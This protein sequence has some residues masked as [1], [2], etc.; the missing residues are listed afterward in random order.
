M[1]RFIT[2]KNVP[3]NT[4]TSSVSRKSSDT[5]GTKCND[6][7]VLAADTPDSTTKPKSKDSKRKYLPKWKQNHSWLEYNQKEDKAFCESCKEAHTLKL[8][9]PT[10]IQGQEIISTFVTNGFNRWKDALDRFRTHESSRFHR[11]CVI[12]LSNSRKTPI[13]TTF[14]TQLQ[15]ERKESRE[16]LLKIFS[17]VRYLGA[18]GIALRGKTDESSNFKQLLLERASDCPHLKTWLERPTKHKWIS[19]EI[20]NEIL[21]NF[22]LAV[23]RRL[24]EKV[25][26]D[27]FFSSMMDET[28]DISTKEQVLICF[29]SV[30][31]DFEISE[32]FLGFYQTTSTT[33]EDLL[34][35]LTDTLLRFDMQFK[36]CR[37]Q[38]YDGAAAMSGHISGLRTR[39]TAIE[40]RALFTHC[41][42]HNLNLVIQDE[43]NQIAE[44]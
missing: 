44:I 10:D 15:Q 26:K 19:P 41:R 1:D 6:S 17:S 23:Q 43:V 24:V 16:A 8:Y 20:Q 39:V 31:N 40:D 32:R 5:D 35:I 4:P 38:C 14:S 33:S 12:A 37:G 2:R 3:P 21:M 36:N 42:G 9:L 7:N 18:Q 27:Q 13:S 25:L 11:E 34:K 28:L 30:D 29:R 22:S